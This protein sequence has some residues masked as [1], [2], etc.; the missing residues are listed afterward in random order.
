MS[1]EQRDTAA[2]PTA[3]C[4]QL[5]SREESLAAHSTLTLSTDNVNTRTITVA[6]CLPLTHGFTNPE[7]PAG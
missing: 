6:T 5:Q 2:A 1:C 3:I 4:M 7:Q